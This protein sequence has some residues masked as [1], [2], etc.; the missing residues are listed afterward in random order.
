MTSLFLYTGGM[1]TNPTTCSCDFDQNCFVCDPDSFVFDTE[2]EEFDAGD[3]PEVCA[4]AGDEWCAL[5][6]GDDE[7]DDAMEW[8]HYV[9]VSA[10]WGTD[11]DYGYGGHDEW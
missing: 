9:L 4:C 5:C 11:E 6:E 8:N 3:A 1:K 7:G 2:S 10:G